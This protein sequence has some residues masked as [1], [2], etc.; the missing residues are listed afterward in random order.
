MT[1]MRTDGI[2]TQSEAVSRV[3]RLLKRNF[4]R[5]EKWQTK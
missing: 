3:K 5:F 1:S 4:L 2:G